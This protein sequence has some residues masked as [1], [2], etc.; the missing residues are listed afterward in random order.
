MQSWVDGGEQTVA[1]E[2]CCDGDELATAW[3]LSP[4]M[5][6]LSMTPAA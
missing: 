2:A 4:C 3:G 5:P 1:W 6:A